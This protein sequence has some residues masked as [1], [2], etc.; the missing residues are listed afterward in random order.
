[1]KKLRIGLYADK[2]KMGTWGGIDVFFER[3]LKALALYAP[4]HHYMIIAQADNAPQLREVFTPLG[5]EIYETNQQD[6]LSKGQRFIRR[7][8]PFMEA[9]L[10]A[11]IHGLHL[12][13]IHF[14]RQFVHVQDLKIPVVL[15]LFDIQHE[16]YPQFFS[17]QHVLDRQKRYG[18]AIQQATQIHAS[19]DYTIQ[20]LQEKYPQEAKKAIRI[21]PAA[22]D[23]SA[24]ADAAFC[25]QIRQKYALPETYLYYPANPWPHKNH[26]RLFQALGQ[27][28]QRD[29]LHLPL[30]LTGRLQNEA[31][32]PVLEW[33]KAA[34]IED[35]LI[36][37]G[38][39]AADEQRAI[40]QMAHLV[41]FPS[42]F[43][44]FGFPLLEAQ[45]LQRPLLASTATCNPEI[46]G[47]GALYVDPFD[48]EEMANGIQRLYSDEALR[49]DLVQ[50]GLQNLQRFSWQKF[51]EA[52]SQ[53]Y[54]SLVKA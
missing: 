44:G 1:M 48:I 27:L 6:L 31:A 42:L 49:Q 35:Q 24:L 36:E 52:T 3:M 14:P 38:F 2:F 16:Y 7:Q 37:L 30:V 5:M 39:L 25:T 19:T 23:E 43:E 12:D 20:T 10:K 4:E 53:A 22:L 21:Y 54:V 50:K 51:A 17:P 40:F 47:E 26:E 33:A 28:R 32:D 41:V 34:G 11:Q 45:H 8:L 29:K 9:G 46:A 13:L 18:N 15:T